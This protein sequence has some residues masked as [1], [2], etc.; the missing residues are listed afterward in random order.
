M[1]AA[2]LQPEPIIKK[3]GCGREYTK[4]GW[5]ALPDPKPWPFEDGELL[6]QRPCPCGSHIYLVL[7]PSPNA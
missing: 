7:I 2:I 3:C 5:E 6:E 4:A 1:M